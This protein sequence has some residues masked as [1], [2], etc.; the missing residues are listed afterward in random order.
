[1]D[2]ACF[3]LAIFIVLKISGTCAQELKDFLVGNGKKYVCAHSISLDSAA[4]KMLVSELFLGSEIYLS[5]SKE[6]QPCSYAS[7]DLFIT[8]DLL[9]NMEKIN[10]Y[11]QDVKI[12]SSMIFVARSSKDSLKRIRESMNN[13]KASSF[14]Y[15][16]LWN[17]TTSTEFYQV[18]TLFPSS[19]NALVIQKLK[20]EENGKIIEDYN[21]QGMDI[22]SQSVDWFPYT[23]FESD[24]HSYGYLVDLANSCANMFNFTLR[25]IVEPNDDWGMQSQFGKNFSGVLGNVIQGKVHMSLSLW[26]WNVDRS[27][28]LD[29]SIITYDMEQLCFFPQI[30]K[31]DLTLFVRPFTYESWIATGFISLI[32]G[33]CAVVTTSIQYINQSES[34]KMVSTSG[35]YFFVLLNAFYGGALTM[36]FANEPSSP[37]ASLKDV[38]DAYPSWNLKALTGNEVLILGN[39]SPEKPEYYTLYDRLMDN[40]M[41]NL[42]SNYEEIMAEARSSQTVF[43]V[44]VRH[45]KGFLGQHPHQKRNLRTFAQG[46]RQDVGIIFPKNSPL[47][48]IFRLG[49]QRLRERGSLEFLSQRWEGSMEEGTFPVEVM[50][51]SGGQLILVYVVMGLGYSLCLVSLALECFWD[52]LSV[53]R[54][55]SQE[56][57]Q[58]INKYCENTGEM[59]ESRVFAGSLD[60][61]G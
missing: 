11:L 47:V 4:S 8:D 16:G 19:N 35:W 53:K 29:F 5:W 41:K 33:I 22:M 21:L 57:K 40:Q 52:K 58:E 30:P 51:L 3:V 26:V 37:F 25:S 28:L 13:Y 60:F 6:F 17:K 36:F 15:L 54:Q 12:Q 43:H 56:L 59:A 14:F 7:F 55:N 46:K 24:G 10:I 50:I 38:V 1:M 31:V 32:I 9:T 20:L 48:P 18:I 34:Y 49:I 42:Y 2:M 39:A 45:F 27:Q 61:H 44:F 23:M